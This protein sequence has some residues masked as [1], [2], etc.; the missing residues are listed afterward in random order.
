MPSFA[1][2]ARDDQGRTQRGTRDGADV[3]EVATTLRGEGLL[4]LRVVAGGTS[5]W[6][7]R[8]IHLFGP[9]PVDLELQLRQ[10]AFMLRTGLPLLSALKV[11]AEQGNRP[12]ARLWHDVAARIR[13][14]A[15]MTE[16]MQAQRCFSRLTISLVDVGERSGNLDHVITRA[17]E[18]MGRRRRTR[19]QVLTALAYPALVVVL[20][21]ATVAFMMASV[22]PKLAAFLQALGRRLPPAT[23]LLVDVA[24]A[25]QVHFV[26]GA[27]FLLLLLAALAIA[28][29]LP[30]SRMLLER[31]LL[32]LPVVGTILRLASVSTFA[33][34]GALLLASGVR[35]T[36][37]LAVLQPLFFLRVVR[38]RL[39]RAR[40]RVVQGAPLA[41]SLVAERVFP[42]LVHSMVA[43]G[44]T[45]GSLDE[46]LDGIAR[47]HDEQLQEL[48]RRLGTLIE[49][50]ILVIVGSVVGFIYFAFFMA[51]YSITGVGGA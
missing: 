31:G 19:T 5:P 33:H 44:E 51:I 16:A 32:R 42:P 4:P 37:A 25:V 20:S 41:E 9:R 15:T 14:G 46:V 27:V 39:A 22:V 7:Q 8:P 36:T 12:L 49:P 30:K 13:A 43:V 3:R 38:H 2:I 28:W 24:D 35:L 10:L 11:C 47:H 34:N 29:A 48:V 21:I 17:A 6:W 1:Y 45:S 26:R 18:A 50:V 23:Q 40:E